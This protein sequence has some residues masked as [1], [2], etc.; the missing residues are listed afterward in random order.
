[1]AVLRTNDINLS[2]YLSIQDDVERTGEF[3][4]GSRVYFEFEGP[5]LDEHKRDWLN[6]ELAPAKSL[7]EALRSLKNEIFQILEQ[8]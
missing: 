6:N 1:M 3:R 4:E 8:R 7:L 5:C 2:A